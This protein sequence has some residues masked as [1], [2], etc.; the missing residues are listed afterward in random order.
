MEKIYNIAKINNAG[1]P[2]TWARMRILV[3]TYMHIIKY[4]PCAHM[5]NL[6]FH[7]EIIFCLIHYIP[8]SENTLAH[9]V[10][11]FLKATVIT[12]KHR[13]QKCLIMHKLPQDP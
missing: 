13:V 10:I 3:H 9:Y 2:V 4:I 5:S 8:P 12:F 6:A 1:K 11:T 7:K